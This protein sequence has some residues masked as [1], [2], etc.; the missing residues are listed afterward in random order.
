VE[1]RPTISPEPRTRSMLSHSSVASPPRSRTSPSPARTLSQK[2][3]ALFSRMG[4]GQKDPVTNTEKREKSPLPTLTSTP[5]SAYV[6]EIPKEVRRPGT[7]QSNDYDHN[8]KVTW[9][10]SS[11]EGRRPSMPGR[12][13]TA[14]TSPRRPS[15]ASDKDKERKNFFKRRGSVKTAEA[16][17]A[18]LSQFSTTIA[19]A[20]TNPSQAP[21]HGDGI[22]GKPGMQR[23]RGSIREAVGS[24]A[25]RPWR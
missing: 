7:S 12:T 16:P 9:R 18:A 4:S 24:A 25:K 19:G 5:S 23:R 13:N 17:P 6:N 22:A 20:V 2:T 21:A 3:Q 11:R 14:P 1:S 8:Q 10:G 15:S